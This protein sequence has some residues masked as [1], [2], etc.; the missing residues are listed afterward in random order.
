MRQIQP[1]LTITGS[2]GTGVSGV[3]AD[4]NTISGLGGYAVSVFTSITMQNTLGIQ[5]FF[6]VP[7]EVVSR[8]I[9]AIVN[10]VEPRIVKIGMIRST[11][12]LAVVIDALVKYHPQYVIYD[13][14]IF[15]VQGDALMDEEVVS[16]IKNRLLPLCS[17][18]VA[19]KEDSDYLLQNASGIN[20]Y[21][22]DN[23]N[24]HG[25][26]NHFSSALA[27]Y[28]S[29]GSNID[30][31]IAKASDYIRQQKAR[32]GD[33]PVK[34]RSQEL[35]QQFLSEVLN[36]CKT[37]SDVLFYAEQLN[38]SSRYLAQVTRRISGKTPKMI[39]DEHIV[40]EI[41]LQLTTTSKNIQ[42]IANDFGFSSQ[43][44]LTKFFRKMRGATPSQF[45]KGYTSDNIKD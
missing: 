45:R 25:I 44:H 16:L 42:E 32:E 7:A 17:I 30:E 31:A 21:L 3:Q 29:Q 12:T 1:I 22:L 35:Y 40:K 27:V 34:G 4:I 23:S 2:D 19:R 14:V 41:E 13:P 26:I 9:E 28:L 20:T 37:Y 39:I 5:D 43:A 8:Q 10:D 15:S 33:Y 36:Y 38:V 6:D 18:V 11:D 24:T